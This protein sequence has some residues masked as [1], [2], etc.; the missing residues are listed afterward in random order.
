MFGAEPVVWQRKHYRHRNRLMLK[1]VSHMLLMPVPAGERLFP[2][3]HAAMFHSA[4]HIH[5]VTPITHPSMYR[6]AP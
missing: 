2:E 6:T 1:P 4:V 3:L 5:K